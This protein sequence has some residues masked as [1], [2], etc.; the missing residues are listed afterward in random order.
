MLQP[1]LVFV[2]GL[3][4]SASL[5]T[6]GNESADEIIIAVGEAKAHCP[7]STPSS[8]IKTE[9]PIS[10]SLN[11]KNSSLTFHLSFLP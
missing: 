8:G 11:D 7:C 10:S 6:A 1:L 9:N 5:A 3:C 4:D 2:G